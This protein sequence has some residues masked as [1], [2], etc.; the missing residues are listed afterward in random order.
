MT[1][2]QDTVKPGG[3]R[4]P[5]DGEPVAAIE[6]TKAGRCGHCGGGGLRHDGDGDEPRCAACS[7]PST[8]HVWTPDEVHAG[9]L[10]ELK[11][12]AGKRMSIADFQTNFVTLVELA[13]ILATGKETLIR[14]CKANG[15]ECTLVKH[16][17]S[18]QTIGVVT[19]EA[20]RQV[21]ERY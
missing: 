4:I 20:A 3:G 1:E 16:P 9:H 19:I 2:G 15:I 14:F 17:R 13:G 18:R 12:L 21:V 5:R 7:R 8:A 10:E 11:G 6:R